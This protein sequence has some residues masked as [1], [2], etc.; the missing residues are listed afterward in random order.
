MGWQPLKA[1]GRV[2]CRCYTLLSQILPCHGGVIPQFTHQ[3]K[4]KQ[5]HMV[6]CRSNQETNLSYIMVEIKHGQQRVHESSMW[7]PRYV[8]WPFIDSCTDCNYSMS[9]PLDGMWH[10]KL[11]NVPAKQHNLFW[12]WYVRMCVKISEIWKSD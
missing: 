6:Q 12:H 1:W 7:A 11:K 10:Q 4:I 5:M 3:K 8:P 2:H 9:L